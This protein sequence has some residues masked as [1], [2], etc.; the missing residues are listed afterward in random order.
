MSHLRLHHYPPAAGAA[1]SRACSL[2]ALSMVEISAAFQPKLRTV[3][4][5]ESAV[6]VSRLSSF[7]VGGKEVEKEEVV[8]VVVEAV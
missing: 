8:V 7:H 1:V 6:Q 4:I 5:K 3:S 2:C